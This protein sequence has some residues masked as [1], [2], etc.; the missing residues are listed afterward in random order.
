MIMLRWFTFVAQISLEQARE[1]AFEL[2]DAIEAAKSDAFLMQYMRKAAG[3][4][5]AGLPVV[6]AFREFRQQAGRH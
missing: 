1:L 5:E 3:F 2:L 6:A 4:P